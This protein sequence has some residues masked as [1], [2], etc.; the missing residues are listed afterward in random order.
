[1]NSEVSSKLSKVK[2]HLSEYIE[3]V[4]KICYNFTYF[5]DFCHAI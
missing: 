2:T 1:M 4:Y 3:T 5:S